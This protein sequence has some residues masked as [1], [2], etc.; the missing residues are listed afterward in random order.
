M[1][2]T[3]FIASVLLSILLCTLS[4]AD[5]TSYH[6]VEGFP[7][8]PP[9]LQLGACSAVAADSK[10]DIFVFTR[11]EPPILVFHS[12]G[13][14]VRSFGD[15]LFKSPHGLR[16]DEHDNIFVTDNADHTVTKFTHD[17]KVVFT[18]GEKGVPGEDD[19][20]F[21]KPADIAF[22]K[23]GDFF[24]ADGYG[25]SRV[26]KFDKTGKYLL[27]WGKKGAGEGEFNLPHNVRLDSKGNVYVA[28]RENRRIQVFTQDGKFLRQ[29]GGFWAYGLFI[30]P[31]DTLFVTDG[32]ANR[33]HHMTLDG[34]ILASFGLEGSKPGQFH[35]PHGVTV[36]ADGAVYITEIDGKRVQKFV[37]SNQALLI[38]PKDQPDGPKAQALAG[39][40]WIHPAARNILGQG[41]DQILAFRRDKA[42]A[43]LVDVTARHWFSVNERRNF[44][45]EE[46]TT[47]Y[48]CTIDG[49][50]LRYREQRQT[51]ALSPGKAFVLNALVPLGNGRWYWAA[52]RVWGEGEHRD[53]EMLYEFTGD[54]IKEPQGKG[55]LQL[56]SGETA[57]KFGIIFKLARDDHAGRRIEVTA[58]D[59]N[60]ARWGSILFPPDANYALLMSGSS[61]DSVVYV[62][63]KADEIPNAGPARQ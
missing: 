53:E 25:N 62:P 4:R 12:D 57:S 27:A 40:C 63:A 59:E 43:L 16:I 44:P 56:H 13:Q 17:G 48:P 9:N 42:G 5:T 15:K 39:T 10:G 22:A 2:P 60:H 50:I 32:R 18:L 23:N 28:D 55:T 14:F 61:K 31:D 52:R 21:N 36:A 19:K 51:V 49:P 30:A 26:V 37:K 34:K 38:L 33:V 6:L 45:F 47:P 3:I 41:I 46:K 58:D 29:F 1:R 35:L 11:A 24:I 20:H 54:P 8:L 7:Q